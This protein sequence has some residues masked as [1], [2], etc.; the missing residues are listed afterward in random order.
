VRLIE[1]YATV[2]DR[3]GHPMSELR[4]DEFRVLDNGQPQEI[5]IFESSTANITCALLL[6]TTASMSRELPVLKN[7]AREFIRSTRPGDSI[8]VYAFSDNL[9]LLQ[10]FT[11]DPVVASRALS[12]L[13]ASGRTALF[14]SVSQLTRQ[15]ERRA[16]KKALIVFTDGADN[17][18]ALNV[19]A[20]VAQA[21]KAGIPIFSVAQGDALKQPALLDL[22]REL[23]TLTGGHTYKVGRS[24]ETGRVFQDV[25]KDLQHAYL[26]GYYQPPPDPEPQWHKI[27][28]VLSDKSKIAK[29]RAR[30]G[31]LPQ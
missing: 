3:G 7:A 19:H 6:D 27:D 25:A 26:L 23:A 5:R 10:E 11:S 16:G 2:Y 17:A 4:K 12:R 29:I 21:Q 20:A 18:S 28:V 15:M 31:Y 22:L 30:T 13:R 1:V 24:N 9:E 8:G 14:D